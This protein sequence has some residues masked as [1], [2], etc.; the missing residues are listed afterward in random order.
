MIESITRPR[1]GGGEPILE[2]R[3]PIPLRWQHAE[4]FP[5]V[6]NVGS[7]VVADLIAVTSDRKLVLQTV[8]AMKDLIGTV[9]LNMTVVAR[10]LERESRPIELK[11]A[12][13]GRWHIGETEMR[14]HFNITMVG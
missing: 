3:G 13:D 1:P 5:A 12:W 2:L 4:A 10:S 7:A 11:V 14:H 8:P 6:R 9:D